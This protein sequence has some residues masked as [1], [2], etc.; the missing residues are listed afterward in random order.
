MNEWELEWSMYLL[1][2]VQVGLDKKL[3][4]TNK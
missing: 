1:C 4:K 3:L 2:N